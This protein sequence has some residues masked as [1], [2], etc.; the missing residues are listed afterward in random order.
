MSFIFRLSLKVVKQYRSLNQAQRK[1]L[2]SG[3]DIG[4]L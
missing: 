3:N 4:K 2:N 1:M